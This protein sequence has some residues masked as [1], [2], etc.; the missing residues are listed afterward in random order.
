MLMTISN[1]WTARISASIQSAGSRPV[2]VSEGRRFSLALNSL[3]RPTR[4]TAGN[5]SAAQAGTLSNAFQN[6][7]I[8]T[9]P[10]VNLSV[11][12]SSGYIRTSGNRSDTM[13]IEDL[14]NGNPDLATQIRTTNA[15]WSHV[16]AMEQS[17]Q[18]AALRFTGAEV[19]PVADGV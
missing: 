14:I 13:Q 18:Y 1:D 12:P 2:T 4:E 8:S 3:I 11:D 16:F 6:A 5:L 10:P 7:G 19:Q 9:N 15:I 17:G